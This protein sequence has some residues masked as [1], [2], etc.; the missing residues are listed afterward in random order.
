MDRLFGF[1]YVAPI[2]GRIVP[3]TR[4]IL[5]LIMD[6]FTTT[7]PPNRLETFL[8]RGEGGNSAIYRLLTSLGSWTHRE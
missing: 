4:S 2:A 8:G 5:K 3:P 1:L 6:P 7:Q